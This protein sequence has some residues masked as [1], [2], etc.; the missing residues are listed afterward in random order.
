MSVLFGASDEA[1]I[2][3]HTIIDSSL[4]ESQAHVP[5]FPIFLRQKLKIGPAEI[6]EHTI[7]QIVQAFS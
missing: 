4:V 7:I 3:E 6:I 1:E 5:L 2:I